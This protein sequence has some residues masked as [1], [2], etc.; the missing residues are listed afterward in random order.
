MIEQLDNEQLQALSLNDLA[1]RMDSIIFTSYL[2]RYGVNP[3]EKPSVRKILSTK[4]VKEMPEDKQHFV[5]HLTF[6]YLLQMEYTEFTFAVTNQYIYGDKSNDKTRWSSSK[7]Q[8]RNAALK[9]ACIISSRIS[10]ECFMQLVYF[11]G[12]GEKLDAHK[13]TFKK[14]KKWLLDIENPFSYFATHLLDAYF[15]DRNYRTP[16]VHASTKLSSKVLQMNIPTTEE[17][18]YGFK[19]NTIMLNIWQPLIDILNTGKASSMQGSEKDFEW[20]KSYLHDDQV[21]KSK[22]LEKIFEQMQ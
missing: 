7:I 17:Q 20:L 16:E 3:I 1:S 18:N 19:L 13:S 22:Y 12:T 2:E 5:C 8:I 10:M 6:N 4:N 15:F 21:T 11:L 14:F 9:Q